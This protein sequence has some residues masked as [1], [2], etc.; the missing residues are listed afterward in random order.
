MHHATLDSRIAHA[1]FLRL[2]KTVVPFA[3]TDRNVSAPG[4]A[5]FRLGAEGARN[6][7]PGV[8]RRASPSFSWAAH[9]GRPLG[10][11]GSKL[12]IFLPGIRN[13]PHLEICMRRTQTRPSDD[14]STNRRSTDIKVVYR[15]LT[16]R[17]VFLIY[18]CRVTGRSA[19]G[20]RCKL[21][22]SRKPSYSAGHA[23]PPAA[24][25][26]TFVTNSSLGIGTGARPAPGFQPH[27]TSL[28][29]LMCS[30]I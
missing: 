11:N 1:S 16:R 5:R 4:G 10:R 25:V 28:S 14:S 15:F 3:T 19:C 12:D 23:A 6:K 13:Q 8:E 17:Q 24:Q 22:K 20:L 21:W 18:F 9:G 27:A 30:T 2:S 7:K 29:S 26:L